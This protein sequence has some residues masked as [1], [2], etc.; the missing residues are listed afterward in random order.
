MSRRT[1]YLANQVWQWF[2][3]TPFVPCPDNDCWRSVIS[4]PASVWHK[5]IHPS[6]ELRI[7]FVGLPPS[8]TSRLPM[9]MSALSISVFH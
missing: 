3:P 4:K 8:V 9:A 1:E 5:E 6:T 7:T 2:F